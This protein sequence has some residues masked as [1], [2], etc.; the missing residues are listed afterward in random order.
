MIKP[1][2][3]PPP[4]FSSKT[5][6]Y[7]RSFQ[8]LPLS[9]TN[10]HKW[11]IAYFWSTRSKMV[12]APFGG[13]PVLFLCVTDRHVMMRLLGVNG[14]INLPHYV[15]MYAL[16]LNRRTDQPVSFLNNSILRSRD[17]RHWKQVGNG[18]RLVRTLGGLFMNIIS[19]YINSIPNMGMMR[20]SRG[21]SSRSLVLSSGKSSSKSWKLKQQKYFWSL[22]S[23]WTS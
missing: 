11:R 15:P 22:S 19:M 12:I 7:P 20:S 8:D 16:G 21:P 4:L 13:G 2:T 3:H 6:N 14:A 1:A 17:A 23:F 18:V 10:P 9:H 5:S